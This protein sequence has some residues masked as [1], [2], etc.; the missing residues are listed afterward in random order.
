MASSNAYLEVDSTADSPATT[1]DAIPSPAVIVSQPS[2]EHPHPRSKQ[3]GTAATTLGIAPPY[4]QFENKIKYPHP[5]ILN[6]R[7]G[8]RPEGAWVANRI[9]SRNQHTSIK[10]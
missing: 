9:R 8:L 6:L 4:V 5:N 1:Q 2:S 3:A 7:C 10:A